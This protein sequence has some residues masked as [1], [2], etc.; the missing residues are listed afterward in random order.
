MIKMKIELKGWE[1]PLFAELDLKGWEEPLFLKKTQVFERPLSM[2]V[3]FEGIKEKLSV[4]AEPA[5]S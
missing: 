2:T 3:S 5:K 4:H 1:E